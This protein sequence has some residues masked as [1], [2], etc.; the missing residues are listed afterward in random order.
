MVVIHRHRLVLLRLADG[1]DRLADNGNVQRTAQIFMRHY[2]RYFRT[3]YT[4]LPPCNTVRK[5]WYVELN[6]YGEP[7]QVYYD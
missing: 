3:M 6:Y 5:H 7:V 2:F 1:V 4:P